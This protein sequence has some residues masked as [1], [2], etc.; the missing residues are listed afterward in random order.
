MS[1]T[2]AKWAGLAITVAFVTWALKAPRSDNCNW[3]LVWLFPLL[4]YPVTIA[5]HRFLNSSPTRERTEWTNIVVH[6]VMMFVLGI[7]VFTAIAVVIRLPLLLI[8]PPRAIGHALLILTGIVTTMT[9]VNLAVSGLGA[10]FA[11]KSSSRLATN[12]MYSRTRNPMLFCT[13][14]LLFSVGLYYQSVWFVG[15]VAGI[16]SPAWSFFVHHY[17]ERELEIRF[18]PSYLE[19]RARTPFLWP[20]NP[21]RTSR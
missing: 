8:P 3:A 13:F 18:G 4:I 20:R 5:A 15:W 16:V 21:S 10:P 9:V 6:Y 7:D 11:I 19:Y 17:E 12:W 2:V 1:T 14:A